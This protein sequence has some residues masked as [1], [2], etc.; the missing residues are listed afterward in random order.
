MREI[1]VIYPEPPAKV[2]LIEK[3]DEPDSLLSIELRLAG[4]SVGHD[5]VIVDIAWVLLEWKMDY[6]TMDL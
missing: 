4:I 6:V 2:L 1:Q 5:T 3:I